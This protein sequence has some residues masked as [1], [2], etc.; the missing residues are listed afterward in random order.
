VEGHFR[1][2]KTFLDAGQGLRFYGFRDIGHQVCFGQKFDIFILF[3]TSFLAAHVE[4]WLWRPK[5]RRGYDM[6]GEKFDM[7]S[8]PGTLVARTLLLVNWQ[9]ARTGSAVS[10]CC[11]KRR[12]EAKRWHSARQNLGNGR[13]KLLH[14]FG[15]L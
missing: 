8:G 9:P 1:L 14:D 10:S 15:K 3:S 5:F 11:Q 13:S 6:A 12:A 7:P 2:H 4:K